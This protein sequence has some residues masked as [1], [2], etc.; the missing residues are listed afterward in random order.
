MLV[1]D[2]HLI[3]VVLFCK[4]HICVFLMIGCPELIS[5]LQQLSI[6]ALIMLVIQLQWLNQITMYHLRF[7]L[8]VFDYILHAAPDVMSGS[9]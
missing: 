8:Y 4:K 5:L 1:Q 6:C 3:I 9:A 7:F 2:K